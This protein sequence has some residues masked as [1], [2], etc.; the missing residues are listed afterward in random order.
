MACVFMSDMMS[1]ALNTEGSMNH[2]GVMIG[3]NAGSKAARMASVISVPLDVLPELRL[4][5]LL[6][7][8]PGILISDLGVNPKLT[9]SGSIRNGTMDS[10]TTL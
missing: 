4:G 10:T 1:L 7:N 6:T 3:G 9:E 5:S 2:S 8:L